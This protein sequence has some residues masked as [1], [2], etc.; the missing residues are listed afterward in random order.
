[1]QEI[2]INENKI[3]LSRLQ[4]KLSFL[5]ILCKKFILGYFVI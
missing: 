5:V 2:K 4:G 3:F 1:M